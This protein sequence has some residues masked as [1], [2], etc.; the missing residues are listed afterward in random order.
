MGL[1]IDYTLERAAVVTL[2]DLRELVEETKDWDAKTIIMVDKH[3]ATDQ[4]DS[5]H[6]TIKVRKGHVRR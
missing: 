6:T 2:E 3:N 5:S 1:N 4:R